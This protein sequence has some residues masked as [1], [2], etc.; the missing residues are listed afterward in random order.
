MDEDGAVT[1]AYGV[2]ALPS[3]FVVD[4]RGTLK[5]QRLGPLAPGGPETAWSEPWLAQQVRGLLASG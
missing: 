2:R 5:L 3:T 1:R 4:Q